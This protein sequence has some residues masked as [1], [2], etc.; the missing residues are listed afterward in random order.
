MKFC[1]CFPSCRPCKIHET[2]PP[3]FPVRRQDR[4]GCPGG[5][6][7]QTPNLG[8]IAAK[9]QLRKVLDQ[10]QDA[11]PAE[12]DRQFEQSTKQKQDR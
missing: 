11:R 1:R 2:I 6:S 7:Y 9:G 3:T 10:F 5:Q 8:R 12:L 4:C